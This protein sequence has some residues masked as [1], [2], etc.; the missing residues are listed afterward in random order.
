MWVCPRVCV[1]VCC[2]MFA[3]L[4]CACGEKVLATSREVCDS[5]FSV[6]SEVAC[7]EMAAGLRLFDPPGLV[8]NDL[9]VV[10]M[11]FSVFLSLPCFCRCLE[12]K[13]ILRAARIHAGI[14]AAQFGSRYEQ[15]ALEPWQQRVLVELKLDGPEQD[16][17]VHL[18]GDSTN[19]RLPVRRGWLCLMPL[20][21]SGTFGLR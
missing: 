13:K 15:D 16:L 9:G 11:L 14:L 10:L 5:Y 2:G 20:P 12:Q 7:L 4:M 8:S 1:R 3:V 19:G 6:C 17:M 21:L 18:G